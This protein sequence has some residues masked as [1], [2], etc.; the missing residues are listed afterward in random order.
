MHS[1]IWFKLSD[2][3]ATLP[4]A[5]RKVT[6]NTRP[7]HVQEGLGM[8]LIHGVDLTDTWY[9]FAL[10]FQVC[11]QARPPHTASCQAF[12]PCNALVY[13]YLTQ[14]LDYSLSSWW[15]NNHL[16]IPKYTTIQHTQLLP[17]LILLHSS[18]WL[19][20]RPTI[21]HKPWC[22]SWS[23]WLSKVIQCPNSLQARGRY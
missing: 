20:R 5:T 11:I 22:K 7:S 3:G 21:D 19:L 1:R 16:C 6:Q 13:M 23:A 2:W 17:P 18:L 10:G 12:H 15:S 14:F 8:R 9:R 4:H